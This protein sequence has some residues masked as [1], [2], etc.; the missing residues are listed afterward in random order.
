MSM[1]NY[2]KPQPP[3]ENSSQ[4]S[5]PFLTPDNTIAIYT[6]LSIMLKMK[7]FLGI[8]A[9]L[10]YAENYL[11]LIEKNNPQFKEA[12]TKALDLLSVEKLYKDAMGD[13]DEKNS[14]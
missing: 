1:E 12:V 7:N 3:T 2:A 4:K 5:P 9:M 6:I 13:G 11:S 8:E 10:E 14:G